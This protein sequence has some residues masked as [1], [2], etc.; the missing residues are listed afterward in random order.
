MTWTYAN[1]TGHRS[2]YVTHSTTNT[3]TYVAP[4]VIPLSGTTNLD[5][6]DYSAIVSYSGKIGVMWSNVPDDTIYFAYHVDGAADS[7]W[8]LDNAL[9]GPGYADNHMAIKS[10]QA[11]SSGQVFASTKTSLNGDQCPPS[12]GNAGNPLILLLIMDGNGGWQ[13]RTV[14]KATDCWTRPIVLLDQE[15]RKVYVFG[16]VPKPG[17]SY[18]S[19]GSIYYKVANLDNP[20]F[21][22]SNAGTPFIQLAAY[23]KI[24]NA[25]GTKQPVTTQSGLVVLAGNDHTQTYVHGAISLGTDTTPP[26]VTGT[27]PVDTA[28]NV[29]ASTTV[30]ATFIE[31]IDPATLD[32]TS[33]SLTD[34]T[35]SEPRGRQRQ[36]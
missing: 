20:N 25:T 34:T 14:A 19:G 15:S 29:P 16:T 36:L 6:F 8:T 33:F 7:A 3:A 12:G 26:T 23:D 5:N 2:V 27:D 10:L 18:G 13:R 32:T 1:G 28:T 22:T 4:Y 35:A 11:D 31:P 30:S 17:S 9:S 24:N 21:D